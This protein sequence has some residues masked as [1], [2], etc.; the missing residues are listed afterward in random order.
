MSLFPD[1]PPIRGQ[2]H[3]NRG[4]AFEAALELQLG[5]YKREGWLVVRQY[6]AVLPQ[7]EGM[8]R[9]VG[10]AAPDWMIYKAGLLVMVDAK[11]FQGER[12][13]LSEVADHQA[14]WFDQAEVAGGAA[15]V[16]L[17]FEAQV[18]W[19]PWDVLGPWWHRWR[20]GGRPAT[21]NRDQLMQVAKPCVGYDF[22]AVV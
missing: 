21:L 8:A 6:P 11:S 13:P 19:M 14:A 20:N 3:A 5:R 9:I 15:G 4:K 12:W 1:Q 10:K 2:S 18:W 17:H 16:V 7:G 22:L